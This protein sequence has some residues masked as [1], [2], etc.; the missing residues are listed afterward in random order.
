MPSTRAKLIIR[1]DVRKVSNIGRFVR[2]HINKPDSFQ[3]ERAGG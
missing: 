2:I 3:V 1:Q